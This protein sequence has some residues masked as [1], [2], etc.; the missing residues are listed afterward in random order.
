MKLFLNSPAA[1]AYSGSGETTCA[2]SALGAEAALAPGGADSGA[3]SSSSS[4]KPSSNAPP[5]ALAGAPS[6]S[7]SCTRCSD[8]RSAEK[9]AAAADTRAEL[10][11]SADEAFSNAAQSSSSSSSSRSR[12]PLP[13]APRLASDAAATAAADTFDAC[14]LADTWKSARD[15]LK[16]RCLTTSS[17]SKRQKTSGK[18]SDTM[19]AGRPRT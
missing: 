4:P 15:W 13:L 8:A 9:A 12:S 10:S 11:G 16:E 7:A 18:S 14:T 3:N 6:C 1:R 2:C 19:R 5:F 17:S